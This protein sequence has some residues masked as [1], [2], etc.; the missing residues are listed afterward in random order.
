MRPRPR[1]FWFFA[2]LPRLLALGWLTS[3]VIG[4]RHFQAGLKQARADMDSRRFE[5]A[6]R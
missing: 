1:V 6:G 2:G 3:W 5:A 4:E